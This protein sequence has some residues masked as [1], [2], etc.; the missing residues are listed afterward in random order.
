MNLKSTDSRLG[1][2]V[3][4]AGKLT[5]NGLI[6]QMPAN[7]TK[8]SSD[9]LVQLFC[10]SSSGLIGSWIRKNQNQRMST[11]YRNWGVNKQRTNRIEEL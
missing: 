8:V 5:D 1:S 3:P 10:L 7:A 6:G 2:L 9:T 4:P 11:V